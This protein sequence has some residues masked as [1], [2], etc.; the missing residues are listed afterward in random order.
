MNVSAKQKQTHRENRC[1][2]PDKRE[3]KERKIGSLGLA[4]TIKYIIDKQ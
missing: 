2:G 1:G 4:D 3:A